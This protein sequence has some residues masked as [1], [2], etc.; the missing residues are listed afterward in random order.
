[1]AVYRLRYVVHDPTE[2]TDG[3]YM[4]EIPA[5]PGCRAWTETTEEITNILQSVAQEFLA[6]Y[7]DNGENLPEE[8]LRS[9]V[10]VEVPAQT[11]E[12]RILVSA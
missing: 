5:L 3:L 12:P 11:E 7:R 9:V 8:V 6:A 4:A 1:M 2:E 10:T